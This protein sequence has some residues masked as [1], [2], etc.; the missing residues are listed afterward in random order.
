MVGFGS[1]I[2]DST[3]AMLTPTP[4]AVERIWATLPRRQGHALNRAIG[5]TPDLNGDEIDAPTGAA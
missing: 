5:F 2:A 3:K 1:I 4:G